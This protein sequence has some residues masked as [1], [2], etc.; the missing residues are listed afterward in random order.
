M[1]LGGADVVHSRW[2]A[3]V[4]SSEMTAGTAARYV[5]VFAAFQRFVRAHGLSNL[6]AV[7]SAL[8]EAFVYATRPGG[9]RPAV[10][11]AR[12]RLTVIRDALAALGSTDDK[13]GD[14]TA[15]LRVHQVA[16][17]R[18]VNPLT[19]GEVAR[20]RTSGRL[21]P[22]DHLRPAAVELALVGGSHVELAAAVVADVDLRAG[23]VKLG[24]RPTI[25]D[26]FATTT[27]AGRVAACRRAARRGRRPWDPAITAL[28]LARPLSTYPATS[29][30]PSIS[31][32]LGRAMAS[33][34]L[35]RPG[36]RPASLREYAANRQYA[37]T[38]RVESVAEQLGLDSLDV[39][40]GY[41]DEDWQL[42]YGDE[43]RG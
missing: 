9:H 36:I 1:H 17:K 11:T 3:R 5:R 31:S 32:S 27:L 8:C 16:Q 34:G 40:R 28:A 35:S 41:V 23:V 37:V 19:P 18:A 38:G 30:A 25:V 6:N 4:D 29:V 22:R 39:A 33:A 13:F 26:A 12:F 20:L 42:R 7:D 15:G 10:A 43:V 21:S 2:K 24:S 14:P